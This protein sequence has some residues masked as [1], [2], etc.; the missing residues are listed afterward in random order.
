MA[1]KTGHKERLLTTPAVLD[2]DQFFGPC[3]TLRSHSKESAMFAFVGA[4]FVDLV[5]AGMSVFGL[6]L[7][8]VSVEDALRARGR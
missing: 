8:S 6:V 2:I 7:L 1:W 3:S 4:H 5:I